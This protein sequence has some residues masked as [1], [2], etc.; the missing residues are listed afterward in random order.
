[1][2]KLENVFM[3]WLYLLLVEWGLKAEWHH[4]V[5]ED[6]FSLWACYFFVGEKVVGFG[7]CTGNYR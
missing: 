2:D 4:D 3:Y 6:D 5:R 7:K 1:M